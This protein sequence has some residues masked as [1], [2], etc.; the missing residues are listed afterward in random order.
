[1]KSRT[2]LSVRVLAVAGAALLWPFV[3]EG[4]NL[5]IANVT[6][7]DAGGGQA[8]IQFTLSWDNSWHESWTE[9]GGT[10]A[11]TNWDAAWVYA[12]FRQNGGLWKHVMLAAAGHT[13]TGGTVI[14]V[15]DDG[16]GTHLGAFVHRSA[17]GTGT[18][19]CTNMRLRWDLAA[20]GIGSP[21]DIDVTVMGVEMVYIPEGAFFIGSGGDEGYHFY[22]APDT[23][24][25]FL[26]TSEAELPIGDDA[27]HLQATGVRYGTSVPAS[28]PKGFAAFYCMKHEITEG[29]YVDFL[30]LL[31]PGIVTPFYPNKNGVRR[32]TIA[33]AAAGGFETSA[34]DRPTGF[35]TADRL[36]TYLDWCG[37]RPMSELEFEK[38][39]R[40]VK[41][42]WVNEYAWGNTNYTTLTGFSG[43]DGSGSE[44]ATPAGAN[45]H[46]SVTF[47]G[48]VRAGIFATGSST[49]AEAGASYYGVMELSGNLTEAAIGLSHAD[50]HAFTGE[51]GDGNEYTDYSPRWPPFYSYA[52][53]ARGG[54]YHT[55]QTALGRVS[56]RSWIDLRYYRDPNFFVG[57]RG[58]RSAP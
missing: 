35:L 48:A 41:Q 52:W 20:A 44:M 43:T 28:Y 42:P 18:V 32:N 22:A 23:A 19:N 14:D 13:P 12:K 46:F 58:V 26:V 3:C 33:V 5:S 51:H 30:N 49:R 34:A 39:C 6:L 8:D 31:D 37:L 53:G 29:Q 50:G 9:S 57:G 21:N 15:A 11:V 27:G 16:G 56:D 36:A 10:I 7:V 25:P 55:I 24:A 4:N 1:M 47:D 45:C 2:N 40:G 17:T 38:A 54:T